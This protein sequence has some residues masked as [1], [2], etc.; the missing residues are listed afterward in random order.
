M[1]KDSRQQRNREQS[2]ERHEGLR[3][4]K[5]VHHKRSEGKR[6]MRQ[7]LRGGGS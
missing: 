6:E 2:L 5:H 7:E 1:K 4:P 3:V